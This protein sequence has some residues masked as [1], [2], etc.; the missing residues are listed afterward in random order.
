MQLPAILA[1]SAVTIAAPALAQQAPA[2]LRPTRDVAVTY[3]A[4]APNQTPQPVETAWSAAQQRLRIDTPRAPGWV[5]V[6]LP[7]NRLRMVMEGQRMVLD[8]PGKGPIPLLDGVP[9]GTRMTRAGSATVAGHRCENWQVSSQEGEGTLCL[10]AD[11][12]LLRAAGTREGKRGSLEATSVR[13]SAQDPARF[14][15]PQGMMSM[16]LPQGLS[17]LAQGIPGIPGLGQR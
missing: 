2:H 15:V 13:Y 12:V 17:G 11:G 10:T 6:D 5:L 16:N 1:L 3:T 7:G 4:S 14:T 9:P 8:L